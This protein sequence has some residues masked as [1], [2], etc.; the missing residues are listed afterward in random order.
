MKILDQ[1]YRYKIPF[2]DESCEENEFKC[3]NGEC[4]RKKWRCDKV[5]DCQDK[6]D[7][8]DCGKSIR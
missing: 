8:D 5:I 7:E 6:S 4:I 3:K 1:K 2:S